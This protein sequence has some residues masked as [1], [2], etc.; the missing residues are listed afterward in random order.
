MASGFEGRKLLRRVNQ[1]CSPSPGFKMGNSR[2]GNKI[3]KL[4][5]WKFWH[6]FHFLGVVL[7]HVPYHE[8]IKYWTQ[9]MSPHL[10]WHPSLLQKLL[11]YW[12]C[13]CWTKR[14]KDV[15]PQMLI[16]QNNPTMSSLI[17]CKTEYY[18]GHEQLRKVI[19]EQTDF[20]F[21]WTLDWK[22]VRQSFLSISKASWIPRWFLLSSFISSQNDA[23]KPLVGQ[24]LPQIQKKTRTFLRLSKRGSR[25]KVFQFEWWVGS[26]GLKYSD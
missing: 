13:S 21:F 11:L 12:F 4:P 1:I 24:I 8:N 6:S 22:S 2:D 23:S 26:G 3:L 25:Q 18:I 10:F 9:H 14:I 5:R 19:S 16:H 17:F 20:S 7:V 15:V